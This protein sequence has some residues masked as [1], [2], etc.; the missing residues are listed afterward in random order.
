MRGWTDQAREQVAASET[1]LLQGLRSNTT[2]VVSAAGRRPGPGSPGSVLPAEA[3]GER[4]PASLLT[5]KVP[6]PR[7][8]VINGV[9]IFGTQASPFYLHLIKAAPRPWPVMPERERGGQTGVI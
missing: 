6:L 1:W 2:R 9:L 7:P 4:F 8:G 3:S 5:A